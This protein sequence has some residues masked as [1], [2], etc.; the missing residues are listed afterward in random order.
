[1]QSWAVDVGAI[2]TFAFLLRRD[3]K[4]RDKQVACLI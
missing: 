4:A 2:G 3:L 1:M